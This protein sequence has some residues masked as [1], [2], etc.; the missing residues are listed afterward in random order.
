MVYG[1]IRPK[2]EY[3]MVTTSACCTCFSVTA[4]G[5]TCFIE[6]TMTREELNGFIITGS[7]MILYND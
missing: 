2:A 6:R 1:N 4:C 3:W 7:D 5:M